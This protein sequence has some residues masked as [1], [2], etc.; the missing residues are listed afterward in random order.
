MKQ[1]LDG[2]ADYDNYDGGTNTTLVAAMT[3]DVYGRT[4]MTNRIAFPADIGKRVEYGV[5]VQPTFNIGALDD[6]KVSNTQERKANYSNMGNAIDLY[7]HG[8]DSL[9]AADDNTT[10]SGRDD[11]YDGYYRIDSNFNIFSHQIIITYLSM[12]I[13]WYNHY[14]PAPLWGTTAEEV[15]FPLLLQACRMFSSPPAGC[16]PPPF[17]QISLLLSNLKPYFSVPY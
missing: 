8:A 12:I 6:A 9:A 5:D 4:M 11:R 13:C 3:G 10:S 14:P 7:T 15:S 16:T 1:V 17:S 2:H